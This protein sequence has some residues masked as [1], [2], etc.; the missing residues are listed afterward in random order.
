[1]CRIVRGLAR[2]HLC[3][4][5]GENI[6]AAIRLQADGH[7]TLVIE[8][9]ERVGGKLNKRSC[10]GYTFDTGPSILTTF[11]GRAGRPDKDKL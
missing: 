11:I 9:N 2:P 8:K 4:A 3:T 10:A 7:Q 1:M 5:F 6:S